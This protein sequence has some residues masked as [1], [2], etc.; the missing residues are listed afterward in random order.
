MHR[1]TMYTIFNM[2][3]S[4]LRDF[5]MKEMTASFHSSSTIMVNIESPREGKCKS[6]T[7]QQDKQLY[8]SSRTPDLL[9]LLTGGYNT[10]SK[11]NSTKTFGI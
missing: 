3:F 8:S 5:L 11:Y 9:P 7:V 1:S 2:K 4:K 10:G 6:A